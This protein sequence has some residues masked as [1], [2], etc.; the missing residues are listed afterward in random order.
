MHP[1]RL[2]P[3]LLLVAAA[4]APRNAELTEG[5]YVAFISETT[6]FSLSTGKISPEDWPEDDRW[7]VDCR[8]FEDQNGNGEFKDEEDALRL[9]GAEDLDDLC[10]SRKNGGGVKTDNES[11]L[12]QSPW[13]VVREAI[14][15]WRGEAILTGEDDLQVTFHHRLPGG[16]DFRFAFVVD[17]AF[18]PT[19]CDV[20]DN[21]DIVTIPLQG[22]WLDEW[23]KDLHALA[24]LDELPPEYAVLA[25][26]VDDPDAKLYYLNARGYQ[27]DP[28]GDGSDVWILPLEW[29]A[30]FGAGKFSEEEFHTRAPRWGQQQLYDAI[31]QDGGTSF[32]DDQ[33]YF[34]PL[35]EPGDDPETGNCM[36][37]GPNDFMTGAELREAL[38]DTVD[39]AVSDLSM[40]GVTTLGPFD[41]SE[42]NVPMYAPM[43]HDNFWRAP[44]INPA[45]LDRWQEI[46]YNYVVLSG[47]VEPGGSV[48]GAFSLLYDSDDSGSRFLVQ[49]QFEVDKIR[50]DRWTTDNLQVE[51]HKENGTFSCLDPQGGLDAVSED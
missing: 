41:D 37:L 47:N 24:D 43:I 31:D 7:A 1:N 29:R 3:S 13:H 33:L 26:F 5:E 48:K 23:S 14:D 21:G 19:T 22:S 30:G 51:K 9:E 50:K 2:A 38:Q 42:D 10:R 34:C 25:P 16:E 17:P 46:H 49:G 4:C 45:G 20:D 8:V 15:P 6:S 35:L 18:Q 11:W 44:D 32:S 28:G 36:Q 40:V 39:N 12:S 27:I